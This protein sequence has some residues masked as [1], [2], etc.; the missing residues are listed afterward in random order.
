MT[1]RMQV[2]PETGVIVPGQFV[3]F[4]DAQTVMGIVR[5]TSIE[6]S[7][8]SLCQTIAVETHA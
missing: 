3:R 6:W 4:R 7:R 2:L 1:L 8:P 5:S